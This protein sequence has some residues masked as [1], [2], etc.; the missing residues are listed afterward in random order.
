MC[1]Y[2]KLGD[3]IRNNT[4]KIIEQ[5]EYYEDEEDYEKIEFGYTTTNY[6]NWRVEYHPPVSRPRFGYGF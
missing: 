5:S 1:V 6:D 3:G 4:I 2:L